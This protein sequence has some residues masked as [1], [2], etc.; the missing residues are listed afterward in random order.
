[1]AALRSVLFVGTHNAGR[2][3]MARDVRDA[4]VTG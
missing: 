1:M 2:S 3:Q 4:V